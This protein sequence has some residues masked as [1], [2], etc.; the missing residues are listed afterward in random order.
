MTIPADAR[1]Q[2]EALADGIAAELGDDLVGVYLHG[3]LVLGCFNPQRSDVDVLAITRSALDDESRWRL[4]PTLL[5]LSGSKERPRTAPYPLEISFLTE[6]QLRPWRYPTPYDVHFSE[7]WRPRLEDGS[8]PRG[9][10]DYDLAAHITI[11]RA[12]GIALHGPPPP[13]VFPEVPPADF[14]DALLRDL[15]WCRE[16]NWKF[17]SVLSASRIW[18]TLCIGGVQSKETG[19]VWALERAPAEFRPLIERALA[20]YQGKLN[21]AEFDLDEANR[22]VDHVRGQLTQA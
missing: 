18:A 22:Y 13:E 3:S 17:Y 12:A 1:A 4:A 6:A 5:R 19:A 15:D 21:D 16:Q 2:L 8:W 14:A 9:G 10:E 20:V 11:V 7:S